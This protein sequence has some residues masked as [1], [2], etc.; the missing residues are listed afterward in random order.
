MTTPSRRDRLRPVEL[1]AISAIVAVFVGLVV[2]MSTRQP[3]LA[4]VFLCIAFIVVIVVLAM[5]Q[6]AATSEQDDNDMLGGH[7]KDEGDDHH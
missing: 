6:L 1:L 7:R 4:A 2:L 5:L 3:E